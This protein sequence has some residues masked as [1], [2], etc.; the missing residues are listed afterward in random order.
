MREII[1][2][3][4]W[5][6]NAI[7]ARTPV[8]LHEVGIQAVVDL[9]MD[10]AMAQ[11][12]RE[13]VY[14]RFPL[15]DGGGNEPATLRAAVDATTSFIRN[16]VATLVACSAGMSRS[17]AIVAAA[18]AIVRGVDPS[19]RLREL[20]ANG[21]RDVAPALWADLTCALAND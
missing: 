16:E 18:L 14:C 13:T 17:P 3:K 7:E 4:L 2:N 1:P 11:L 5:I 19:E 9:A 12:S 6:G 10:E 20:T 15:V 21:P 8:R